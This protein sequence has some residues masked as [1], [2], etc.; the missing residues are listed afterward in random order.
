MVSFAER[1]AALA[2]RST[3]GVTLSVGLICAAAGPAQA[4]RAATPPAPPVPQQAGPVPSQDVAAPSRIKDLSLIAARITLRHTPFFAIPQP[5]DTRVT[6]EGLAVTLPDGSQQ[7]S[8]F[9]DGRCARS[10]EAKGPQGPVWSI[11]QV[12]GITLPMRAL[13]DDFC[14]AWNVARDATA[15]GAFDAGITPPGNAL[16]MTG[17]MAR[18]SIRELFPKRLLVAYQV[19]QGKPTRFS[20]LDPNKQFRMLE[21]RI[22]NIGGIRMEVEQKIESLQPGPNGLQPTPYEARNSVNF[23][24]GYRTVERIDSVENGTFYMCGGPFFAWREARD[25]ERYCDALNLLVHGAF[26]EDPKKMIY[27]GP[28]AQAWRDGARPA[29]SADWDRFR[30]LAENALS[31]KNLYKAIEYFEGGLKARPAWPEGY[32]NA[33]LLYEGFGEWYT[34]ANRMEHYLALEPNAPDAQAAREKIIIW[35]EKAK[36]P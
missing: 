4:Q 10:R 3:L 5:A 16:A 13:A 18:I 33:A 27:F 26:V 31:E 11:D 20:G 6:A 2:L 24:D 19:E 22:V 34:A 36:Q 7:L 25:A 9:A 14:L 30:I 29:P 1:P 15:E 35:M 32:F 8:S 12:P 23:T 28:T 17:G 21:G